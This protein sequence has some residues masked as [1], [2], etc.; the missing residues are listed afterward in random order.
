M[1]HG[2]Q[3]VRKV[4]ELLASR[5]PGSQQ[6]RRTGFGGGGF[7]FFLRTVPLGNREKAGTTSREVRS[8]QEKCA[9]LWL[10][11][12]WEVHPCVNPS[13]DLQSFSAVQ[14]A[15][16]FAAASNKIMPLGNQA[17]AR[18]RRS[19]ELGQLAAR[20]CLLCRERLNKMLPTQA[21]NQICFHIQPSLF[22][23][24]KQLLGFQWS[25]TSEFRVPI[26]SHC[27]SRKY[28]GPY[29]IC[30]CLWRRWRN[31][32]TERGHLQGQCQ[33]VCCLRHDVIHVRF[34]S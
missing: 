6:P 27:P 13:C 12:R 18:P 28:A 32:R 19:W 24:L 9:K 29:L 23:C 21:S 14:G 25:T 26:P 22:P 15:A 5:S 30:R 7:F 3:V 2:F 11:R 8:K 17:G 34:G 1:S 20:R 33:S 4:W 31:L 10:S 16:V